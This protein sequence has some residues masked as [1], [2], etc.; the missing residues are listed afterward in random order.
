MDNE[1]LQFIFYYVHHF[2]RQVLKI[3]PPEIN[4]DTGL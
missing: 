2:V 3:Q 1:P 4:G